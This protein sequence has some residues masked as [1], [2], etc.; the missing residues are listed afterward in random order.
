MNTSGSC[1]GLLFFL[2]CMNNIFF[3]YSIFADDFC[4]SFENSDPVFVNNVVNILNI[5]PIY[6]NFNKNCKTQ[7]IF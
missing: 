6:F 5:D 4:L 3:C 2:L 1:L 7:F